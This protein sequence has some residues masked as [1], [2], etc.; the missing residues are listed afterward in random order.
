MG[1]RNAV[2]AAVLAVPL[3]AMAQSVALTGQMGG[4]ALLLIDGQPQILAVGEQARGVKLLSLG[5]GQARVERGGVATT[6][7]LGGAPASIGAGAASSGAREIVLSA[8]SGGHFMAGGAING[9]ATRF[10]VDTGATLVALSR[11]EAE[12]LGVDWRGGRPGM[13]QTAGGAMPVHMLTLNTVRV[14]EIE[15]A[16]VTAVVV[17]SPMPYVLLGNSFLGRFQMRREND[18][19]RLELRP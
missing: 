14:G 5:D 18:I 13:T 1:V 16:N 9:R 3:W 17:E 11:D 2:A 7:R 12:R 4:K 10:M 8:G 15:L 19:M 6:L